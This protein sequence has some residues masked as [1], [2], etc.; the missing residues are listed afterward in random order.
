M[1]R[2]GDPI[3]SAS[4]TNCVIKSRIGHPKCV[5]IVLLQPFTPRP[6]HKTQS[7]RNNLRV[8]RTNFIFSL[9]NLVHCSVCMA[10]ATRLCQCKWLALFFSFFSRL[11]SQT[12]SKTHRPDPSTSATGT[13]KS[14]RQKSSDEIALARSDTAVPLDFDPYAEDIDQF[15]MDY[16]KHLERVYWRNLTYSQ[17]MYGADMLGSK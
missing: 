9:S 6:C 17:P 12:R 7:G 14:R 11:H 5:P 8:R 1:S 3:R 13:A 15:T 4:G 2:S 16:C 10:S